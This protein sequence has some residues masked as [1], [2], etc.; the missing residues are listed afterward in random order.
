MG[1]R[2]AKTEEALKL[3]LEGQLTSPSNK[4]M[5]S[6]SRGRARIIP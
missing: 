1:R 3:K 5:L 4:E 2:E 6:L